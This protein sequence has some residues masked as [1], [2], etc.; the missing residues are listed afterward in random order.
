[1]LKTHRDIKALLNKENYNA[2]LLTSKI[3][4]YEDI[5]APVKKGDVLGEITYYYDGVEAVTAELHADRDVSRSYIKQILSYLLNIWF[6][7]FLGIVVVIILLRRRKL[8]RRAARIRRMNNR[9]AG[10]R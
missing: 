5:T 1:V 6:L 8:M 3:N 9:K 10:R 2:E 4:V 7:T